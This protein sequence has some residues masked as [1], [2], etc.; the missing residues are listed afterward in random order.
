[1]TLA[2][3]W[4]CLQFLVHLQKG[5]CESEPHQTKKSALYLVRTKASELADFPCV[6]T[7]LNSCHIYSPSCSFKPFFC[8]TKLW[9]NKLF[10]KTVGNKAVFV[11]SDFHY[12]KKKI[13]ILR[14]FSNH[15]LLCSIVYVRLL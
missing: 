4:F 10:L 14:C 7:P 1:M 12:M 2:H 8:G 5:Q 13:K 15:L 11:T 6:N 3:V 9:E